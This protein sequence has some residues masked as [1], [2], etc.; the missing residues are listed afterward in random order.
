M[1]ISNPDSTSGSKMN[2]MTTNEIAQQAKAFLYELNDARYEY[3][4][5]TNETWSYSQC[6]PKEKL[7][8]EN[9][10]YPVFFKKLEASDV[11][12]F[13]QVLNKEKHI[14]SQSDDAVTE[15]VN[16]KGRIY[17][18]AYCLSKLK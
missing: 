5:S 3:S 6:N 2:N 11:Q 9:K 12:A 1:K 14:P 13:H 8:L 16:S 18:A 17:I 7:I 10:Y 15:E 4:F